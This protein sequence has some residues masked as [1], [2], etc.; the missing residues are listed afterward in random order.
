MEKNILV[1]GGAG[2]IGSNLIKFLKH[3]NNSITSIDNYSSGKISNHISG[4]NYIDLD[5]LQIEN[6]KNKH[7]DFCFHLAAQSRVQPSFDNPINS[8]QSNVTGTLKVIEWTKKNN[9]K[10]IYAGSSSRHHD[11]SAS[12]YAMTKFLGEEVCKMFKKSF[13]SN[14]E[15][16]R[17][18]NVYGPNEAVDIK[19]GNVI[20]I[21]R[22]KIEQGEKLTI[23]GD[24]EQ[25]R[26]F[27]H[28]EDLVDGLYK[29]ALSNDSNDDA[30]ELGTGI[31]YSIN[32]LYDFFNKRFNVDFE[33]IDDQPGNYRETIRVNDDSI[34]RLKWKPKD[35]LKKYI[36]DLNNNN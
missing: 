32:E 2:F 23:V 3:K 16:A 20:G 29:I 8:Y 15:I 1:T 19:F 24:G 30:W 14:I 18:Y 26:D 31:N 21:W 28:V 22:K 11:P 13:D 5:I 17:F 10:T 35:R 33:R 25:R 7:F 9:I 27:I 6:F 36:F 34:K 4:V 12:P